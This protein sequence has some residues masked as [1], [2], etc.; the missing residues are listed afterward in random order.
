MAIYQ[1]R[2][3]NER[4]LEQNLLFSREKQKTSTEQKS[5]TV[6]KQKKKLLVYKIN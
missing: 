3:E 4:K 6:F 5:K 1:Y 2:Q